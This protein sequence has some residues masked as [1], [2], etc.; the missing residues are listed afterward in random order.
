[1]AL[2]AVQNFNFVGVPLHKREG[3]QSNDPEVFYEALKHSIVKRLLSEQDWEI[4]N[5][6]KNSMIGIHCTHG[7]NR[8]SYFICSYMIKRMNMT[9]KQAIE[10]FQEARGHEVERAYY[11]ADLQ[12]LAQESDFLTKLNEDSINRP[13]PERS[14]LGQAE[15]G[16]SLPRKHRKRKTKGGTSQHQGSVTGPKTGYPR[17]GFHNGVRNS[18]Q[19]GARNNFQNGAR[20]NV[21]YGARN[22]YLQP[23]WDVPASS[24]SQYQYRTP[25]SKQGHQVLGG[26]YPEETRS[27]SGRGRGAHHKRGGRNPTRGRKHSSRHY[28]VMPQEITKMIKDIWAVCKNFTKILLNALQ[29]LRM[30]GDQAIESKD[31]GYSFNTLC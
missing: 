9:V 28:S 13:A 30:N 7:L 6:I 4:V 22:N 23:A 2:E 8:T 10:A 1:M 27:Y 26:L 5:L 18:F 12:K 29:S 20:N 31:H 14:N 21:H 19:E 16:T 25:L 17:N 11:I 3:C 24:D 15:I